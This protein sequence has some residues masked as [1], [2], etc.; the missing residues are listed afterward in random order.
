MGVCNL[1][2]SGERLDWCNAGCHRGI[3]VG[4]GLDVL[5]IYVSNR[6]GN[7]SHAEAH[8]SRTNGFFD[9]LASMLNNPRKPHAAGQARKYYGTLCDDGVSSTRSPILHD[10]IA[11]FLDWQNPDDGNMRESPDHFWPHSSKVG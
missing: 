8:Q 4:G 7:S 9:K 1:V 10:L 6:H 2:Q 5:F 3:D 11:L